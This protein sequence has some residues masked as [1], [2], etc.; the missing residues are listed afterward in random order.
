MSWKIFFRRLLPVRVFGLYHVPTVEA[1]AAAVHD[2][3][4]LLAEVVA[5]V[6]IDLDSRVH[7]VR[8]FGGGNRADAGTP[9]ALDRKERAEDKSSREHGDDEPESSMGIIIEKKE[10]IR[11]DEPEK[12]RAH[13]QS[14]FA[15][16]L[17][18]PAMQSCQLVGLGTHNG[19]LPSSEENKAP[20]AGSRKRTHIAP[21]HGGE[22]HAQHH[23]RQDHEPENLEHRDA[24][25]ESEVEIRP[26]SVEHGYHTGKHAGAYQEPGFLIAIELLHFVF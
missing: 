25:Q 6:I 14:A 23:E 20:Q 4:V 7:A 11:H 18:D 13:R 16:H 8:L 12:Q 5:A 22:V 9:A 10:A 1:A 3:L 21:E 2:A 17:V 26:Q 19:E 15:D 24:S